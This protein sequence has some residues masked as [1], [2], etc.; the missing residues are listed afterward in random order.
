MFT[1]SVVEYLVSGGCSLW[2]RY[3]M[4]CY[5]PGSPCVRLYQKSSVE[6]RRRTQIGFRGSEGCLTVIGPGYRPLLVLAGQCCEW[7]CNGCE[8]GHKPSVPASQSQDLRLGARSSAV[9]D[10]FHLI[11][12]WTLLSLSQSVSQ[13]PYLLPCPLVALV[14]QPSPL[15]P[16]QDQ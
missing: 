4:E 14:C 8:L 15:D 12:L 5:S 3:R 2:L 16:S 11:H 6:N 13:V 7:G 1:I 10:S 9:L